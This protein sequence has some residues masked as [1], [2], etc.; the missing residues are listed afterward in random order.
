MRCISLELFHIMVTVLALAWFCFVF[1]Y[2][3]LWHCAGTV[4]HSFLVFCYCHYQFL[5]CLL[6]H[7]RLVDHNDLHWKI[8]ESYN[9]TKRKLKIRIRKNIFICF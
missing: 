7:V 1:K 3:F 4:S 2:S 6:L 8:E 5:K 9:L